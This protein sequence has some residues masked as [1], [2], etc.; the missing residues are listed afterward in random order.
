MSYSDDVKR[1]TESNQKLEQEVQ[2]LTQ[3]LRNEL[4]QIATL[5]TTYLSQLDGL[6]QHYKDHAIKLQNNLNRLMNQKGNCIY[7]SRFGD[8][9][10][11]GNHPDKPVKTLQQALMKIGITGTIKLLTSIE[12]DHNNCIKDNFDL[13]RTIIDNKNI[14]IES[15]EDEIFYI[16]SEVYEWEGIQ[17]INR[18]SCVNSRVIFNNVNFSIPSID[19]ATYTRD[20][21]TGMYN[22]WKT[23]T[24]SHFLDFNM[25]TVGFAQCELN[26]CQIDI[27]A[28]TSFVEKN[29]NYDDNNSIPIFIKRNKGKTIIGDNSSFSHTLTDKQSVRTPTHKE[30]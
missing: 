4:H 23:D 26:N 20:D 30:V 21:K 13:V 25:G 24:A 18:L 27:G 3:I 22:D 7:L 29:H 5:R 9:S 17:A 8:D 1:L 16:S 2:N 14:I 10:N 11:E 19:I 15:Y 6:E 28:N 12:L